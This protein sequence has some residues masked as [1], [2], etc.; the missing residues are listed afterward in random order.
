MTSNVGDSVGLNVGA[1]VGILVVGENVGGV[2]C[3]VVG[4]FVGFGVEHPLNLL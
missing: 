2:G 1:M 4:V 3:L